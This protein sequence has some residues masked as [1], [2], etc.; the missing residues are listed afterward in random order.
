[1]GIAFL[2]GEIPTISLKILLE[3]FTANEG[4]L[5]KPAE[6]VPVE[7]WEGSREI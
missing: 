5:G 2:S 6:M 1:M 7:E 4:S 3:V